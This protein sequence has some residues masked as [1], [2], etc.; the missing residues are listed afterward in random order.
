VTAPTVRVLLAEDNP[1]DAE[2]EVRELK[3]AGLRV[4]HRVVDSQESFVTA[5][6]EFAPDAI[7]CDFSMPSFDGM[8]ALRL[9]R[10]MVP[11]TPFIFV[12]GRL[13]EDYAVRALKSGATDYVMKTNLI[14]L[15]SVVERSVAEAAVWRERRRA[16]AELEIAQARLREREAAL[17]R[18]QLMAK[19]A[20]VITA[21][22][23]SFVSWSET[24]P[25]LIGVS[26]AHMMPRSIREWLDIVH[27]EDRELFR[28]KSIETGAEGARVEV[29]YRLRRPDGAWIQMR[30]VIEPLQGLGESKGGARWFSTLQDVTERK[31]AETRISRLNRVYAVLSGINALI[32][33]VRDRDELFRE[34]C[35]I[36]VDA[37]AF[38]LAWVGVVNREANRVTPVASDGPVQGYLEM[39]PMELGEDSEL[40]W[41]LAGRA[42]REKKPM[43]ANDIE[44]DPRILLRKE[45]LERG[46][47]SLVVLPLLVSEQVT[48]LLALY[49]DSP[50]F[51]DDEEMKLLLELAGDISFALDHIGKEE[52]L[53]Y[54]AYYDSLTGL[55]N[56]TFFQERLELYVH[57]A[58]RTQRKLAVIVADIERFRT[59][60]D[61]LGR[62][63]GDELLKQM[64]ARLLREANDPHEVGRLGADHFAVVI[65]E[66]KAEE[67]LVRMIESARGRVL[68]EP[69]SVEDH[70]LRVSTKAGI[71]LFP[72]DAADAETLLRNAEAALRKAKASGERHLFYTQ[73]MTQRVA[74]KLTLEN[75]LR[76]ALEKS[77]FV[78]H[79]QPKINLETRAIVGVEA[80]IRWQSPE[81]GLVPP[82]RFIPL[83]EETG[84]ILEVG[85]WA[86]NR[87][88]LD[89]RG[90]A[91]K[92]LKA[93]RVAVNVSPIQLRQRNFVAL[94][95]QAIMEGI[96]PVGVD[97]EITESVIMEDIE[98]TIEKL[99]NARDLGMNI[100][101]DDFGTGYS[102]LAYLA[103][104]PVGFLKIDR[105]FIITMLKDV[106]TMTLVSTIISLAH[107]LKLKVVAEGVE[108]ED[109]A[110]MLRLLRCDEMQGYLFSKPLPYEGLISLLNK[111]R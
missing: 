76:Q 11:E 110:H 69:F 7:L 84:L 29:E 85:S 17:T 73:Q 98:A 82:M 102:S 91:E 32:V 96:A 50:G 90:W 47:R 18:A 63:G 77:E 46:F 33:R 20:H 99:K 41:G 68:G 107:S 59:I 67:D 58:S 16:D 74:E 6:R 83:L 10:E 22:D 14:R 12:S 66:V 23:G 25:Q 28:G 61:T 78:L 2:I 64:A 55:A 38:K 53:D 8:E 60:N 65:P 45:A 21:P 30:Q 111:S 34:V 79:Y 3:R 71:A 57:E 35:K 93:P 1:D 19:L 94:L 4:A 13:G 26:S 75:K 9:A 95:E 86:L 62:R 24:L 104:L 103:K 101:I 106:N 37:G 81:L 39:M 48:G 89:H 43:V 36:A 15:P 49:A 105:S 54:L 109:Q 44:S 27:P 108:S 42:V 5:L 97:L 80:L 87:A 88:A 40:E 92:R 70:E 52:K 31:Q 56:R 72:N 100:A 51:F